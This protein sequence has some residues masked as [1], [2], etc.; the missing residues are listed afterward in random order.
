MN[1]GGN[2]PPFSE[3]KYEMNHYLIHPVIPPVLPTRLPFTSVSA[4]L[5]FFVLLLLAAVG[6]S[7]LVGWILT[8][9]MQGK[10]FKCSLPVTLVLSG[11]LS[12]LTVLRFGFTLATVQGIL[13]GF[14]LLY[15]SCSDLTD[16]T[17]DDFLWVM[18]AMLGL[19]SVGTVG[20]PS[21]LIGAVMVFVPQMLSALLCKNPIG[22]ADIKLTTAL[23]FLLGWQKGLAVL[24]VGMLL[25]VITMLVAQKV[26]K[27]KKKQP[28]ALIPFLSVAAMVIFLI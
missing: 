28:F 10:R 15:A 19:C 26:K 11:T 1:E 14:V 9:V 24:I 23:A 27:S 2:M 13:L 25:A 22:G 8:K 20:L 21:M 18:V 16:H 12:L 3:R 7:V 5:G 6:M 17:M 4:D